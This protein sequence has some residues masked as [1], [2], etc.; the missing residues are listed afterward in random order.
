MKKGILK[1]RRNQKFQGGGAV[2]YSVVPAYD[3]SKDADY[4]Q[5]QAL[6]KRDAAAKLAAKAAAEKRKIAEDKA[7]AAAAKTVLANRETFDFL[8][9]DGVLTTHT[10]ANIEIAHLQAD[11]NK[12]LDTGGIN[13]LRGDGID[14][15]ADYQ[16][17]VANITS[18]VFRVDA[19]RKTA[20][21]NVVLNKDVGGRLSISQDR[22]RVFDRTTNTSTWKTA[23]EVLKDQKEEKPNYIPLTALTAIQRHDM[24]AP[25]SGLVY[26]E[27]S[28]IIGGKDF[29]KNNVDIFT[30]RA[31][32]NTGE[33]VYNINNGEL[34]RSQVL[35][36]IAAYQDNMKVTTKSNIHN[37]EGTFESMYSEVRGDTK[38]KDYL[39]SV[40]IQDG[41]AIARILEAEKGERK[42]A[43]GD[44]LSA[45]DQM[46][47]ERV[48]VLAKYALLGKF[49]SVT[50]R[51]MKNTESSDV[52]SLR[53][54]KEVKNQ[55]ILNTLTGSGATSMGSISPAF[56][57]EKEF[58]DPVENI[59]SA[60]TVL[61]IS[62]GITMQ[63]GNVLKNVE[64]GK[65][66]MLADMSA[67]Y[68]S[69]LSM[70]D[71]M[72]H[73]G[74]KLTDAL[75]M[76][77]SELLAFSTFSKPEDMRLVYVPVDSE[78]SPV[79][80][81]PN[82]LNEYKQAY[83]IVK[84]NKYSLV[85]A[86]V[87]T[88]K[89]LAASKEYRGIVNLILTGDENVSAFNQ[90]G[91]LK[92]VSRAPGLET[93]P[94]IMGSI[95]TEVTT[96]N[97]NKLTEA[98]ELDKTARMVEIYNERVTPRE[99]KMAEYYYKMRGDIDYDGKGWSEWINSRW[100]NYKLIELDVMI[101]VEEYGR[102]SEKTGPLTDIQK[103]SAREKSSLP[104]DKILSA[105]E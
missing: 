51:V 53:R 12:R 14:V 79:K 31:G 103:T 29:I 24:E 104:A 15:L 93:M 77:S 76:R 18:K 37:L 82:F 86:R 89:K 80:N 8:D 6:K 26:E 52:S 16:R 38:A 87:R 63:Q 27:I 40:V 43:D 39:T 34:T 23:I 94:V 74:G 5:G 9:K 4:V 90:D 99:T 57:S 75:G 21:D 102:I 49:S 73:N 46:E 98:G 69:Y 84:N 13:W 78:G 1:Y 91:T 92:V 66:A 83:A 56:W 30:K 105:L 71:I 62:S 36:S 3:K 97:L 60:F 72:T 65:T 32:T 10:A 55:R 41:E 64:T 81:Y 42:N 2:A 7:R 59:F 35:E 11:Y 100:P 22:I 33:S 61:D 19:A 67:D 48:A 88:L 95:I 20:Y 96:D 25:N 101:P 45:G 70:G 50:S 54:D 68:A 58:K 17:R 85:S 44:V 28:G 47:V